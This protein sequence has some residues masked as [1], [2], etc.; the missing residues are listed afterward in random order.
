MTSTERRA[1]ERAAT[2]DLIVSAALKILEE[3]GT[4]ALTMRRVAG[5]VEYTAPIVYQHFANKDALVVELVAH[6]YRRLVQALDDVEADL[7]IDRRMLQV[8]SAYVRFAGEHPHL[9]EAMNGTELGPEDRPDVIQPALDVLS[10][11]LTRWSQTHDV[12]LGD[13]TE[14]CE[15]IWG[16]LSGMAWIGRLDTIGNARAQRLAAEAL[17]AVLRGWQ[18]PAP[19]ARL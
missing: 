6:G 9:F 13:R 4:A 17:E 19:A 1:R 5:D 16:T 2:R 11:L 12:D 14:A 15:I 8:A 3:E 7:D 18:H 10:G